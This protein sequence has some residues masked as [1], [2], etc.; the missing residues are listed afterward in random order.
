MVLEQNQEDRLFQEQNSQQ[1]QGRL[2]FIIY[3]MIGGG[4][5]R[6]L[7]NL[8]NFLSSRGWSISILTF[9]DGSSPSF[10][11]LHPSI[12]IIPL[13]IM[14]RQNGFLRSLAMPLLRPWILRRAIL[15]T[16]PDVVIPFV[17]LTNI[18]T[19]ISTMGL[20]VP[21]IASEMTHPQYHKM[22][23]LWGFVREWAY[24]RARCVVVQTD[25]GLSFFSKNIQRRSRVIPNPVIVPENHNPD[26]S[27]NDFENTKT[28]IAMGRLSKEKGFDL[29]LRAFA[30]VA[31]RCPEWKLVVWGEGDQREMLESLRKELALTEKVSLPGI[32]RK[33]YEKMMESD[34]FV[35]SSHFE[36]FPNVLCE[37]M[38]CGL[39]VISFDCPSGPSS[40]IRDGYDGLLVPPEDVA[41][42][43]ISMEKVISDPELRANLGKNAREITDRFA[44]DKVAGMWEKLFFEFSNKEQRE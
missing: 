10:Y 22:G 2:V 20:A 9:D 4:A 6:H 42:L 43:A 15:K 29:L 26:T 44:V 24:R 5:Q 11:D 14:R 39:P 25:V 17:D 8:V 7:S 30:V 35:L 41:E 28:I 18:L 3:K 21:V 1:S 13:S 16:K 23:K 33:P 27:D 32:T 31:D 38:A 36:G 37:A 34:L 19:L 40:I 12:Q